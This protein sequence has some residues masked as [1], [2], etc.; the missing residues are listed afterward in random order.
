MI[1]AK[2]SDIVFEEKNIAEVTL[3]KLILRA[4]PA[5][6]AAMALVSAETETCCDD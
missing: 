4:D 5:L 3:G 1:L 6:A 2:Q